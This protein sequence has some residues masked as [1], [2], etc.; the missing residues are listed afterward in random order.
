M[1]RFLFL[2]LLL[3][4]SARAELIATFTRDGVTDTRRDRFPALSIQKG[5]PATPF[6]T[7]GQFEVV[8]TGK[9]TLQARQRLAFSFEGE[10]AASLKIDGAEL[11]KKEGA[12][13]G[14]PSETKRL[15]PGEHT[16]ELTYKSKEDGS[17][18]FRV[19]WQEAGF[20]RQTIPP[21]AFTAEETEPSKAGD[22]LRA[23]RL[24]FTQQNCAKCHT[25][26]EGF[27]ATPMPETGEIGPILMGI[28]DRVTEEWLHRWISDPK[29]LRPTTH[30]RHW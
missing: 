22:L 9:L 7:P 23:G 3:A 8:W 4:A 13:A 19:Y 30:M 11:Y 29:H 16:F 21:T 24:H 20:V 2:A 14:D 26:N 15:N 1:P 18:A 6:L 25:S 28:G 27:G 17:A 12:L 10:G 5:E